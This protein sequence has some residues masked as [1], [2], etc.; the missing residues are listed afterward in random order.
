MFW[1][2]KLDI[3][4]F[5]SGQLTILA[6]FLKRAIFNNLLVNLFGIMT[7]S[8]MHQHVFELSFSIEGTTE[9]VHKFNAQVS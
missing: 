9:K 4:S 6:T 3:L 8:I 5:L 1:I 7:I 2:F